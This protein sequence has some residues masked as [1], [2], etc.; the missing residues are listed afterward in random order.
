MSLIS[1]RFLLVCV[2]SSAGVE[3]KDFLFS[4]FDFASK[5]DLTEDEATMTMEASA[6]VLLG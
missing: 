3:E 5:G 6:V 4:I 2:L 1:W